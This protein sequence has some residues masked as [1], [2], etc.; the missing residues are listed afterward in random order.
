[1]SSW[2]IGRDERAVDEVVNLVRG[3]VAL[4]LEIAQARVAALAFEERLA[5]LG[6]GLA[7][8]L[9]LLAKELVE[10]PAA[11]GYQAQFHF[12]SSATKPKEAMVKVSL[13]LRPNILDVD[14]A[15]CLSWGGSSR[16]RL[17]TL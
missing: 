13:T 9:A 3:L 1:M 7:D 14:D 10:A 16:Q 5:E 4:V 12:T 15:C 2:S 8:E 11:L 6:Q 17:P